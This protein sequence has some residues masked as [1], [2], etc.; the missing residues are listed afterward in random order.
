MLTR[1]PEA[2]QAQLRAVFEGSSEKL[3]HWMISARDAAE[4]GLV[5]ADRSLS[6]ESDDGSIE[7][8]RVQ[9][10]EEAARGVYRTWGVLSDPEKYDEPAVL[11]SYGSSDGVIIRKMINM[12]LAA[13]ESGDAERNYHSAVVRDIT[14]FTMFRVLGFEQRRNVTPSLVRA[15]EKLSPRCSLAAQL[16]R[17][18]ESHNPLWDARGLS[19]ICRYILR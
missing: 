2:T 17:E 14:N 13:E 6:R 3:L 12:A 4:E 5:S 18:E 15:L 16:L 1:F 9:S 10:V 8:I 11:Y 7:L 19:A